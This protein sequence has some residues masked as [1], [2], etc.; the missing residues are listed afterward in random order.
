MGGVAPICPLFYLRLVLKVAMLLGI[1]SVRLPLL[2]LQRECTFQPLSLRLC[3]LLDKYV[4]LQAHLLCSSI[5]VLLVWSFVVSV[6]AVITVKE[7]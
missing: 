3:F 7:N 5:F 6:A 1:N 2:N 4:I